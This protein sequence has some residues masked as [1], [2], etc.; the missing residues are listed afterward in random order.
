EEEKVVKEVEAHDPTPGVFWWEFGECLEGRRHFDD[1]EVCYKKAADLW[2]MLPEPRNSLGM[3]YMRMGRETDA[4]PVLEKAFKADPF[5]VRVKNTIT[6][7]HHLDDYQTLQTEH[8][9][10]RFDA[11]RDKA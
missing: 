10:I 5:N 11:G 1:A 6:V 8:F 7:L 3:L 9:V 2:P 4:R